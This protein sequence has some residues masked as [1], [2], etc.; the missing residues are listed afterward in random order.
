MEN[1]TGNDSSLNITHSTDEELLIPYC[2]QGKEPIVWLNYSLAALSYFALVINFLHIFILSKLES[3]RGSPYLIV[4]IHISAGDIFHGFGTGTRLLSADSSYFLGVTTPL[5]I[6]FNQLDWIVVGRNA[7]M[8]AASLERYYAICRPM[9]YSQTRY[10]KKLNLWMFLIWISSFAINLA[11]DILFRDSFCFHFSLGPTNS[12]DFGPGMANM[13]TAIIP[14]I[15]TTVALTR[16]SV[17]LFRM[18][19]R[20]TTDG[21]KQVKAA[22]HYLMI[23]ITLYYLS[24]IPPTI[25]YTLQVIGHFSLERFYINMVLVMA[26][27]G[28]FNT[29]IYG[30]KSASYRKCIV[31]VLTCESPVTGTTTSNPAT[32]STEA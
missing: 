26:L 22:T 2:Y 8:A 21:E 25:E 9:E 29:V 15:F 31:A 16:V 6:V 14:F 32:A 11:R 10:I 5:F 12:L 4:L 27:Y 1:F 30:W 17:E 28:I 7:I 19:K 3:I 20:A 18:R 23:I 13:L 24:F